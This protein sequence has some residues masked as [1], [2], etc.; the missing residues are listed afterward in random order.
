MDIQNYT[1]TDFNSS[2]ASYTN[3][4][5]KKYH[6]GSNNASD[7]DFFNGYFC[8]NE[9]E[10]PRSKIWSAPTTSEFF[11]TYSDKSSLTKLTRFEIIKKHC[12]SNKFQ[13]DE[14]AN[15]IAQYD[16]MMA[17]WD[18]VIQQSYFAINTV[19][20]YEILGLKW[21]KNELALP[22]EVYTNVK[23]GIVKTLFSKKI[24]PLHDWENDLGGLFD[25]I[26]N[27][28]PRLYKQSKNES[29]FPI[30]R[31]IAFHK[32]IGAIEPETILGMQSYYENKLKELSQTYTVIFL[33]EDPCFLNPNDEFFS[34]LFSLQL[35]LTDPMQVDKF[36]QYHLSNTFRGNK[37]EYKIFLAGSSLKHKKHFGND[38]VSILDRFCINLELQPLNKE[39]EVDKSE[40]P[41][42]E[43]S[44]RK[45]VL[46]LKYLLDELDIENDKIAITEFIKLVT[47][48]EPNQKAKDGNIYKM[49]R[50]PFPTSDK[51]LITEL[52]FIRPYFER[53]GL[54]NIVNKIN[55]EIATKDNI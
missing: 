37:V 23:E 55:K 9:I 12:E 38:F 53:L 22:E 13:L 2:I 3:T 34:L 45:K 25:Y 16:A 20:I 32:T 21:A 31:Y 50:T 4:L 39:T 42:K 1:E 44:L 52:S 24:K 27:R 35:F 5:M 33:D 49:I 18:Y 41:D 51:A 54:V 43:V 19:E 17:I 14:V 40:F 47:G 29:Q 10:I 6:E 48:K 11:N 46:A 8:K 7:V 36:L 28:Y 15:L 26:F 30:P